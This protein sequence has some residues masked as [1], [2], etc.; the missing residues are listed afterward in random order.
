M[1][2][3]ASFE[4][5]SGLERGRPYIQ[6]SSLTAPVMDLGDVSKPLETSKQ[7]PQDNMRKL[8]EIIEFPKCGPSCVG[9]DY[10]EVTHR[11]KRCLREGHSLS[12]AGDTPLPR[13]LLTLTNCSIPSRSNALPCTRM[14]PDPSS[15][16]SVLAAR[17]RLEE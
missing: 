14:C 8:T 2:F 9:N 7:D 5:A 10:V 13:S 4:W 17:S 3:L 11:F 12:R 16:D 6:S 1:S 15:C